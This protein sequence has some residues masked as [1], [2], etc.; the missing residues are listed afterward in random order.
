[1]TDYQHKGL[2]KFQAE[3]GSLTRG[4]AQPALY[5][6]LPL[7]PT[8][9]IQDSMLIDRER[10]QLQEMSVL[11]G[12]H[13]AMRHVIEASILSQVQRPSGHRSSMFGLNSHLGR[14]H[15]FDFMDTLGDPNEVPT[16]DAEGSRARL[17]Q[18]LGMWFSK[19]QHDN[20]A[21][22]YFFFAKIKMY[23]YS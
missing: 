17:E 22:R 11:Y 9:A 21:E 6:N 1:M 8:K 4:P 5:A 2:P 13:M 7:H 20:Y 3:T 19:F 12:S 16:L 23:E 18:K 15:D 10:K 14:Y